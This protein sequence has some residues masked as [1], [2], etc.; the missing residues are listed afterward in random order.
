M[1]HINPDF[2]AETVV[3]TGATS[4]IGREIALRFGDAGA[5]VVIGD[6]EKEPKDA[7][8]PT[9]EAIEDDGGTATFVETDVTDSDQIHRLV[10]EAREYGGVDVMINNAGL[11]IGG[12]VRDLEPDDFDQIHSVNAKGVYFGI[13]A[14]ANDM[15]ERGEPGSIINTASISS[16]YAQ[17]EQVQYDST[18][19][20]V[21]MITRGSA[22]ELAEHGIRVNAVG[23][24]QIATEFIEGW[25]EEAKEAAQ[26]GDLIKDV[27]LGRAG[28]PVD[29]AGA[30]LF[31]ASAEAGYITGELLF[32]DG[33]WQVF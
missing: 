2:E 25:S 3:I 20:A 15:I 26:E 29:V 5:N 8:V 22:L 28:T 10:S 33:G 32:V 6:I 23:P 30:Y 16:S 19:G 12:S 7:D 31:L 4:G 17:F 24:G 9:H 1:G 27:P 13:Q 14:A 11:F 18:K 21:R